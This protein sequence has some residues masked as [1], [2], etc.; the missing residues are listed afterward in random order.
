MH[1]PPA[2]KA[3]VVCPSDHYRHVRNRVAKKA[4]LEVPVGYPRPEHFFE[5][6]V[7]V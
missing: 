1:L 3:G 2:V 4:G 7:K 6:A 5:F